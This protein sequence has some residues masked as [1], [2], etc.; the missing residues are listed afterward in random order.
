MS[1]RGPVVIVGGG[2]SALLAA[3][4]VRQTDTTSP[5]YVVEQAAELGGLLGKMDGGSYGRF[6][7]GMHTMTETGIQELDQLFWALLPE[8]EWYVFSGK[9]RDISGAFY[10]GTL[11]SHTHYPDLRTLGKDRYAR[12]LADFFVNLQRPQGGDGGNIRD[13]ARARFGNLIAE[14]VVDPIV[15][16]T[17]RLPSERTDMLA[18][19]LLPLDRVG[20]FDEATFRDLMAAPLLRAR[21]AYPEQ[22]NLD[23]EYSSGRSSY[24]P[25][26]FGIHRVIDAMEERAVRAGVTVLKQTSVISMSHARGRVNMVRLGPAGRTQEITDP[27]HLYWCVGLPPLARHLGAYRDGLGFDAPLTTAI[28]NFLFDKPAQMADLYYFYCFDAPH[29]AYRVT[30][31]GAYCPG[32]PRA[33]GFPLCVELLLE[34]GA[35]LDAPS[36]EAR[37]RSELEAFGVLAEGTK[38]LYTAVKV[39]ERGFPL[40]SVTNMQSLDVIRADIRALELRNLTTLSILSEPGLFFQTDVVQDVF[41]KVTANARG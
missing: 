13:Y 19:K 22:R 29:I 12:Y 30:N 36:C 7:L 18:A 38:A 24:Y 39:L 21:V 37:A 32:A 1:T 33:G 25:K 5:V 11:Q 6:D 17:Y 9:L 26:N 3:L 16:R 28:V 35:P 20:L 10:G 41:R 2:I 23:L 8:D 27:A 40:P 4:L 34:S 15:R 14:E 31:Y